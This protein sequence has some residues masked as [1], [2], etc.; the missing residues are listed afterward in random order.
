[1][2]AGALLVVV[3]LPCCTQRDLRW[4]RAVG[5]RGVS[6][7]GEPSDWGTYE[8][9]AFLAANRGR[10]V[11]LVRGGDRARYLKMYSGPATT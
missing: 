1:M 3:L 2:L 4:H 10:G 5:M 7:Y 9:V 6:S 8:L 11:F